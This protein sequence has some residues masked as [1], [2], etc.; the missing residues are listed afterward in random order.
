MFIFYLC[1]VY[2][3]LV[4]KE[5]VKYTSCYYIADPALCDIVTGSNVQRNGSEPR[6]K[7]LTNSKFPR[8]LSPCEFGHCEFSWT[9]FCGLSDPTL[10]RKSSEGWNDC[11]RNQEI[12]PSKRLFSL[13]EKQE[14]QERVP[15]RWS[16]L[17]ASLNQSTVKDQ[18]NWQSALPADPSCNRCW[19]RGMRR[20]DTQLS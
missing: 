16:C 12:T 13:L 18:G 3:F 15:E 9:T 2:V 17:C 6:D 14:L 5:A 1:F 7:A 11:G 4:V 10:W 8:D 19:W 20:D